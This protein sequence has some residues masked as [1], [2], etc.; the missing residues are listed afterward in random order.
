MSL[1]DFFSQLTQDIIPKTSGSTD[2]GITPTLPIINKD[3]IAAKPSSPIKL[4][5]DTAISA[6][7]DSYDAFGSV[8]K[9]QETIQNIQS[10]KYKDAVN[11]ALEVNPIINFLKDLTKSAVTG[12]GNV[13]LTGADALSRTANTITTRENQFNKINENFSF[14]SKE[15]P[16][17]SMKSY[18]NKN[19]EY[20]NQGDSPL[21]AG[22]KSAGGFILDEPFGYG[23]KAVFALGALA[24]GFL[25]N[26]GEQIIKD[27]AKTSDTNIIKENISKIADIKDTNVINK[28]AEDLKN[29]NT[30]QGVKDYLTK[31][32]E[33]AKTVV[34]KS[35]NGVVPALGFASLKAILD[36]PLGVGVNA[37][38][39][40]TKG[41]F[42]ATVKPVINKIL[43]KTAEETINVITKSTTADAINPELQKIFKNNISEDAYNLAA[44]DLAKTTDRDSVIQKLYNI[45]KGIE[46]A[47]AKIE[48]SP[49][50]E[51][52]KKYKTPEEFIKSQQSG[53]ADSNF[54]TGKAEDFY[55][56]Q[57]SEIELENRIDR[58]RVRQP[59]VPNELKDDFLRGG[60]EILNRLRSDTSFGMSAMRT[61]KNTSA[62]N[63]IPRE[64]VDNISVFIDT[65][66]SSMFDD[67]GLSIWGKGTKQ[68]QYNFSNGLV[69]I[70]KNSIL[71]NGGDFDRTMIHELWHSA[72]RYL[73]TEKVSSVIN[74]YKKDISIFLKSNPG[75][76]SIY[77][78]AANTI[79]ST[80][81]KKEYDSIIEKYGE[82]YK[83]FFS[84]ELS[85][86]RIT[87]EYH[88]NF[89][90]DT[91]RLKNIDEWFAEH[92]TDTH[93]NNIKK[94]DENSKSV[95]LYLKNIFLDIVSSAKS[96]FKKD[97]AR[98]LY[99]NYV[100]GNYIDKLRDTTLGRANTNNI[101]NLKSIWEKANNI[102]KV[103][104]PLDKAT[105]IAKVETPLDKATKI[106]N[107]VKQSE[108]FS[109]SKTAKNIVNK[110]DTTFISEYNPIKY[111]EKK[112][113]KAND[114]E[115]KPA[116]N[117]ARR[118]EQVNGAAGK[119]H[120]D[121]LDFDNAVIT[122]I[123]QN[124]EDFNTYLFLKRTESRLINNPEVK[125]VGEWTLDDVNTALK[126]LS[127][128]TGKVFSKIEDTS[129]IYQEQMD[130]ALQL[131][132]D[133]GRISREVYN[134]IKGDNDFYAPFKVMKY[135][136]ESG[137]QQGTRP[138]Q[139][140]SDYTKAITGINDSEFELQ[141]ILLSS[142]EN[143]YKS[144]ILAEQN[145][146]MSMLG[147]LK[148]LDKTGL[149][150]QVS[151][152][153]QK[154]E[155]G[156]EIVRYF[157]NGVEKALQVP[158]DVAVAVRSYNAAQTNALVKVMKAI[159][160]PMRYGATTFNLGFSA[161][162]FISDNIRVALVSKYGVNN[163][164][165]IARYPMDLAH[166]LFSSFRGNFGI[167]RDAMYE[168]FLKSGA[169]NSTF[170]KIIT[171]DAFVKKTTAT[172]IKDLPKLFFDKAAAFSSTLEEATKISTLKR[173]LRYED[174]K[175]LSGEELGK[176][177]QD[178]VYEVRNFGGSP[179][180]ARSAP[181][182]R[183]LNTLF[184]FFNARLQGVAV[185]VSRVS[186]IEGKSQTAK[187]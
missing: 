173:A 51:E 92:L 91:Y 111:L 121:L 184:M 83:K 70:Y 86:D 125:K 96:L 50:F 4:T 133:S 139:N 134:N 180:F 145:K 138:L 71:K 24:K 57:K 179:D 89:D 153:T 154:P 156:F 109:I 129:K 21:W 140:L 60:E 106:A 126:Q 64:Q 108:P 163:A 45:N 37:A 59:Y 136:E 30:E 187:V 117:M 172:T 158:E 157:K 13:A 61:G 41:I 146:I 94:L 171:P 38:I 80:I 177:M 78:D 116:L 6:T 84:A 159:A 28:V 151:T 90:K 141:N 113:Y 3:T 164:A 54:I 107:G 17:S 26:G 110:V 137:A 49:L 15:D 103:E 52:A 77:N 87:P 97:V 33:Q 123:K 131:Q 16:S 175:N 36:E 148:D 161:V 101:A 9:Q 19:V 100:N 155:K 169:A 2:I 119:A 124:L 95:L 29:I 39:K 88:F 27:I 104:T 43:G 144:R 73:P 128:K 147:E 79:K 152:I 31:V 62:L 178:I 69:T 76:S 127:D 40:G 58:A 105:K 47:A 98:D 7:K 99:K 46:E 23:P 20:K 67:V 93:L 25:K 5:G 68:G 118:F 168:E 10:G 132:V 75:L 18:L 112:V 66:G 8:P 181:V 44:E 81:S 182:A 130:K 63:Y 85:K 55:K 48:I 149:V 1:Q 170:Q 11:S 22:T 42:G 32:S 12:L 174:V 166:G 122:P 142:K 56:L 35:P 74:Q 160:V 34:D 185:D 114:I 14:P 186:G 102:S 150:K 65:L 135:I 162:N 143:I 82:S 72:S 165:D 53:I 183:D 176:V 115:G 120:A 167:G